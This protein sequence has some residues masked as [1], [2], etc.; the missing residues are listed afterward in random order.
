MY[1]HFEIKIP[2]DVPTQSVG[3]HC[4]SLDA[5]RR[6]PQRYLGFYLMFWISLDVLKLGRG[7]ETGTFRHLL[8]PN[9]LILLNN[10]VTQVVA[11]GH[12]SG[13]ERISYPP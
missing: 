3:F 5:K 8:E 13:L 12:A 10:L 9:G 2:T 6:K 11:R 4:T 7:G 1:P